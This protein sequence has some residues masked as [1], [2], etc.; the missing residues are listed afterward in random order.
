MNRRGNKRGRP[1]ITSDDDIERQIT[2]LSKTSSITIASKKLREAKNNK[3]SRV[4]RRNLANRRKEIDAK[5]E[6]EYL[7][8]QQL[9]AYHQK[10]E[11]EIQQL[12]LDLVSGSI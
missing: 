8:F 11:Q 5:L 2:K 6:M 1:A 9:K 12:K 4:Y 7:K 3:A 10:L